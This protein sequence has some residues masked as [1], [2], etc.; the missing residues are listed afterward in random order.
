[1][2]GGKSEY[3]EA[4]YQTSKGQE[5]CGFSGHKKNCMKSG[6]M[7]IIGHGKSVVVGKM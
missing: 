3:L 4:K 7:T 1:M 6:K 2:L 5:R